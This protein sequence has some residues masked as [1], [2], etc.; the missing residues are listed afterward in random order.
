MTMFASDL[1]VGDEVGIIY[2]GISFSHPLLSS[3][4]GTVT[5]INGHGHIFVT[6]TDGKEYKFNKFGE[7]KDKYVGN[8]CDANELRKEIKAAEKRKE[9][10]SLVNEMKTIIDES[11]WNNDYHMTAERLLGM[12]DILNKL[13]LKHDFA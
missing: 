11:R 6:T 8:I 5:R 13:M 3:K 1:K 9:I 4:F 2:R 10:N 12:K 7:P